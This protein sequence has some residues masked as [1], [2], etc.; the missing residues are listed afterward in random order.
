MLY[1]QPERYAFAFQNYATITMMRQHLAQS[2]K[3]FKILERSIFSAQFCF[4]EL[5]RK[6]KVF[7]EITYSVMQSWYS[8]LHE[9]TKIECNAIIYLQ[10]DPERAFERIQRRARTEERMITREYLTA[11]HELHEQWLVL[12]KHKLPSKVYTIDA[13]QEQTQIKKELLK[14]L[15][16]I[17]KDV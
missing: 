8:F 10:I 9:T 4:V 15:D 13:T 3:K 2:H 11:L 14:V 7:D 16:T 17:S 12:K 5:M 6:E 1:Q